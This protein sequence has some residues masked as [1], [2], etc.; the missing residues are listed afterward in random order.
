M[1]SLTFTPAKNSNLDKDSERLYQC[2]FDLNYADTVNSNINGPNINVTSIAQQA[3]TYALQYT[4]APQVSSGSIHVAATSS[5]SISSTS[6]ATNQPST[7]TSNGATNSTL[8]D[9]NSGND[10]KGISP[11]AIAGIA[12]GAVAGVLVLLTLGFM[13]WRNKRKVDDLQAMLAKP[14][15]AEME[16]TSASPRYENPRPKDTYAME[17]APNEPPPQ[18][19]PGSAVP[20]S[21][22]R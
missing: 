2:H 19:L 1:A 15:G 3:T 7:P 9:S 5:A 20:V 13:V 22:L 14:Q 12:V 6:R 17:L 11:G 4:S 16:G 10:D 8:Q 18:E 21:E